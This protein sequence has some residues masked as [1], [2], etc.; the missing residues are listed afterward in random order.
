MY[1][2]D[3][4]DKRAR[5]A[6]AIAKKE[7][8][9]QELSREINIIENSID[10]AALA[11]CPATLQL[12]SET[13]VAMD[14]HDMVV[15]LGTVSEEALKKVRQKTRNKQ[16]LNT[17]HKQP[18][19]TNGKPFQNIGKPFQNNGKPV[20]TNGKPFQTNGKPSKP[21]GTLFQTIKQTSNEHTRNEQTSNEQAIKQTF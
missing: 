2:I 20:Q 3:G 14:N 6:D 12:C 15:L 16:R 21:T 13:S 11:S 8:K 18:F 19:Q 1:R 5:G 9:V 7:E 17:N 4:G 10:N